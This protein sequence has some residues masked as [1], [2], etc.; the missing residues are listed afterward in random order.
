MYS[1]NIPETYWT[2]ELN[3]EMRQHDS[4]DNLIVEKPLKDNYQ[5]TR[6]IT[7]ITKGYIWLT[8]GDF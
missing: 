4:V 5:I 3:E 1:K 6:R 7:S 8:R 2:N